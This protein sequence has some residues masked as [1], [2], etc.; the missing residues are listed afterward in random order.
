MNLYKYFEFLRKISFLS[1]GISWRFVVCFYLQLQM[2]LFDSIYGIEHTDKFNV[3][4]RN[5]PCMNKHLRN[6]NCSSTI[7]LADLQIFLKNA[8]KQASYRLSCLQQSN[9]LQQTVLF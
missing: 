7:P 2:N 1:D 8:E 5:S 4:K 6:L 3:L 9:A